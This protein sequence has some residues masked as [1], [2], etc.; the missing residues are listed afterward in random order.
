MARFVKVTNE[1]I[2]PFIEERENGNTK[3]KTFYTSWT[4]SLCF[5]STR[6]KVE[7]LKKLIVFKKVFTIV[8]YEYSINYF[9]LCL[10]LNNETIT[11]QLLI[12]KDHALAQFLSAWFT[13]ACGMPACAIIVYSCWLNY[14]VNYLVELPT[15]IARR[16]TAGV[17]EPGY[18]AI[19]KPW[20]FLSKYER[21]TV[22]LL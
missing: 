19:V 13:Y 21:K 22:T 17:C 10:C 8:A 2:K 5:S 9:R 11:K 15:T 18:R 6:T 20:R 12:L 3:R 1:D 14:F 16:H 7:K 4:Y